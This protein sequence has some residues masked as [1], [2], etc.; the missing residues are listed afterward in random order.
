MIK[1]VGSQYIHNEYNASGA[2]GDVNIF[3]EIHSSPH[4][5]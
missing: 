4:S 5:I 2:T 1:R 3:I